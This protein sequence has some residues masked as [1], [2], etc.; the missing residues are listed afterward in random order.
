LIF[1]LLGLDLN[2]VL[3]LG[4][5]LGSNS[6]RFPHSTQIDPFYLTRIQLYLFIGSV[7]YKL[8]VPVYKK[9]PYLKQRNLL[10]LHVFVFPGILT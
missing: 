1:I 2:Q 3:H 5:L 9:V 7:L 4:I 6:F 8:V 10:I